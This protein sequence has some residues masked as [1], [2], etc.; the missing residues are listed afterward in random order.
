MNTGRRGLDRQA[1]S[2]CLRKRKGRRASRILIMVAS[3]MEKK[4]VF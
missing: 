1:D 4:M 2:E 3:G